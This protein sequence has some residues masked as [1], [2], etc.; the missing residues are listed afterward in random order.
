MIKKAHVIA[1]WM[2]FFS[3]LVVQKTIN[4]IRI[5]T[6]LIQLRYLTRKLEKLP[7]WQPDSLNKRT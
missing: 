6:V 5:N 2:V 4:G 3:P 7:Y 1:K